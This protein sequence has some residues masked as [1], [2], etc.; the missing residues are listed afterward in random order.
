VLFNNTQEEV[1]V[2]LPEQFVL[3]KIVTASLV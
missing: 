2:E 1:E 3:P